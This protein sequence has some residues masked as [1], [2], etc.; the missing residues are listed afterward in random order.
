[1]A[2][3]KISALPASTV[4]LAGTE[5]L[6]IVQSSATRQVTVANLTVGRTQTSNGIVQGTA[7]TGYNYTANTPAAGMTSQLLNW[8]EE[9]TWTPVFTCGTPGDLAITYSLQ[10][11]RYTRTGNR[12]TLNFSIG[13]SSFT[14]TTASGNV[15]ITGLPFPSNSAS[16]NANL[17]AMIFQGFTALTF[18]QLNP[19]IAVNV[20]TMTF[21][22]SGSGVNSVITTISQYPSGGSISLRGTITYQI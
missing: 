17:G 4:P 18:T 10:V 20:S 9:G 1:M 13:S 5:V 22:A 11:G 19:N 21:I 15:T 7:A 8:Y 3:L 14:H 6:P 2:D 12:C 16:G